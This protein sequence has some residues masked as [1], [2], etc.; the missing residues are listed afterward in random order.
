M[1]GSELLLKLR[2]HAAGFPSSASGIHAHSSPLSC[3]PGTGSAGRAADDSSVSG[4]EQAATRAARH[5]L[6]VHVLVR[7][8]EASCWRENLAQLFLAGRASKKKPLDSSA[9]LFGVLV[10]VLRCLR[11]I[12]A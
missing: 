2:A 12:L 6:G 3:A 4:T 8:D 7:L 9:K 11:P 5:R 1:R 10:K